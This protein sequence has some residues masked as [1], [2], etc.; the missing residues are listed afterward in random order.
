MPDLQNFTLRSAADELRARR[1]SS[2]ELTEEYLERIDRVNPKLDAY[3]TI[4][5]E[6]A[7][8]EA[9]WA[10]EEIAVGGW[11]G[12]LHGVPGW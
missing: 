4:S 3:W 2:L 10:T 8:A 7:L 6:R 12:P 11:R 5:R 9:G 1:I